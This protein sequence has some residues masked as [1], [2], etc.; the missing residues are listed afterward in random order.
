[1]RG[2]HAHRGGLGDAPQAGVRGASTAGSWQVGI[3]VALAAFLEISSISLQGGAGGRQSYP[4]SGAKACCEAQN[5]FLVAP[6][7]GCRATRFRLVT[8]DLP[9]TVAR[10]DEANQDN[11]PTVLQKRSQQARACFYA[12]GATRELFVV[13]A[14]ASVRAIEGLRG[15]AAALSLSWTTIRPPLSSKASWARCRARR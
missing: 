5:A 4:Q 2:E 7:S 1:M 9:L 3:S 6:D 15:C 8:R 11:E 13:D 14:V 10:S 12:L